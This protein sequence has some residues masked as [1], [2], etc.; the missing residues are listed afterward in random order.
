MI[1][2]VTPSISSVLLNL[3]KYSRQRRKDAEKNLLLLTAQQASVKKVK[4]Y[5]SVVTIF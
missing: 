5:A 3:K 2:A 1:E 4:L